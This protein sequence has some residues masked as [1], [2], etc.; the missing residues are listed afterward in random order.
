M[1]ALS[2]SRA[3]S[4]FFLSVTPQEAAYRGSVGLEAALVR[5]PIAQR[6][7]RDVGLTSNNRSAISIDFFRRSR[8]RL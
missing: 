8:K 6:Q 4:V 1:S 5:Q 7:Q 2:C 3:T